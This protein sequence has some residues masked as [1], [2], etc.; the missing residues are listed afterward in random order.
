M[1]TRRCLLPILALAFAGAAFAQTD[2]PR[3]Y[4]LDFVVKEVEGGKTV[5][6][7]AFSAMLAVHVPGRDSPAASIRAGGRVPV[8]AAGS[9]T[10]YTMFD[11]GVNIDV[12]ELREVQNDVTLNITADITTMTREDQTVAVTRNNRW[13]GAVLAP[14]KK[15]TVVFFSD[16]ITSKRQL[17]LELTATPVK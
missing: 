2:A 10:Q 3:F 16:D 8:Y 12:R 14:V 1:K 6:S 7:R 5:N 11:L 4:K 9:N 15:P 13:N 17:Q